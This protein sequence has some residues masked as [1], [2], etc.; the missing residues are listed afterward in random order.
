MI[1]FL[2]LWVRAFRQ[3][4]LEIVV[5]TNNG[6]E[7]KNKDFKHEFLKPYKD[8]SLSGVVTVLVQ[9]FMP[10]KGKSKISSYVL[11]SLK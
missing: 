2:Q 11:L 9:Q 8:N 4:L 10:V 3:G 6:V 5:N 1:P 7:R